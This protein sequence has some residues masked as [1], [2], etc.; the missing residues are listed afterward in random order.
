MEQASDDDH[1]G[2][3]Y[4]ENAFFWHESLIDA[5]AHYST[6]PTHLRHDACGRCDKSLRHLGI[7]ET[8]YREKKRGQVIGISPTRRHK[9]QQDPIPGKE[10]GLRGTQIEVDNPPARPYTCDLLCAVCYDQFYPA[11]QVVDDNDASNTARD[12]VDS[13]QSDLSYLRTSLNQHAHLVVSRWKKKSKVKRL[14]LLEEVADLAP[15][16]WAPV[17]FMNIRKKRRESRG[18]ANAHWFQEYDRLVEA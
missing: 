2:H 9:L 13:I 18:R 6:E 4:F 14:S 3:E 12:L 1:D 7:I 10:N 5:R 15:F 8:L 16:R 11:I 17:H